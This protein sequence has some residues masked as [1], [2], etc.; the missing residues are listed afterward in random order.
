MPI[1]RFG[2]TRI[3]QTQFYQNFGPIGIVGIAGA[4]YLA[5]VTWYKTFKFTLHKFYRH[6]IMG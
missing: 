2:I 3:G 4:A 6:V 5:S 1:G